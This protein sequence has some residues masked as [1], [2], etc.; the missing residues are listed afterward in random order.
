MGCG[1]WYS[2]TVKDEGHNQ[3]F[4]SY[5][6]YRDTL[7]QG[8]RTLA[9]III[10]TVP[11]T[12]RISTSSCAVVRVYIQVHCRSGVLEYLVQYTSTSTSPYTRT[13]DW[14]TSTILV[15]G[16]GVED[17]FACYML[18]YIVLVP[19]TMFHVHRQG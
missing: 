6:K 10:K 1:Q 19:G 14:S 16:T 12:V 3:C 17:L 15:P 13:G 18:L 2:S 9:G 7:A 5:S 11:G 4:T 8:A